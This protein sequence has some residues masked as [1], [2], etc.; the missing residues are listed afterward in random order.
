M[1]H[2]TLSTESLC[3]IESCRKR[4]TD[5]EA[6]LSYQ[7]FDAPLCF[8]CQSSE[9]C[10]LYPP[11][12]IPPAPKVSAEHNGCLIFMC[13]CGDLARWMY[14]GD[15]ERAK[16]H[17]ECWRCKRQVPLGRAEAQILRQVAMDYVVL[18]D[19]IERQ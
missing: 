19:H 5:D 4:L 3:K 1:S 2:A 16:F 13:K 11:A 12:S 10:R 6:A 14:Y 15:I 17:A 18:A 9:R 8:R 7:E